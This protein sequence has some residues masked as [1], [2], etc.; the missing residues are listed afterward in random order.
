MSEHTPAGSGTG[1]YSYGQ[2][3]ETGE[4]DGQVWTGRSRPDDAWHRSE[5]PGI[6]VRCVS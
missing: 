5:H 2:R 3:Q 4:W 1:W 6:A